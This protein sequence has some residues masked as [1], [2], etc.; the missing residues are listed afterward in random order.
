MKKSAESTRQ[1]LKTTGLAVGAFLHSSKAGVAQE[2]L[3]TQRSE[4][5]AEPNRF[6]VLGLISD[7]LVHDDLGAGPSDS[8]MS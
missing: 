5:V 1:F 6:N 4:P 7:L 8:K 2:G 3:P